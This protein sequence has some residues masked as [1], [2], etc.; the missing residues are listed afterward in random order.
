MQSLFWTFC[1]CN[2][3]SA[4]PR[5]TF[6]RVWLHVSQTWCWAI[7]VSQQRG[8]WTGPTDIHY[9]LHGRMIVRS[10]TCLISAETRA[11]LGTVI[12]DLRQASSS[13]LWSQIHGFQSADSSRSHI[14]SNLQQNEA[15]PSQYFIAL[16]GEQEADR[17]H[18]EIKHI[19]RKMT[20]LFFLFY[21]F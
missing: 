21:F 12:T 10:W 1:L 6:T 14:G 11:D 16:S 13:Q 8:V 9:L 2:S 5:F 4:G 15:P 19:R 17:S 18:E 20:L 3:N 7:T